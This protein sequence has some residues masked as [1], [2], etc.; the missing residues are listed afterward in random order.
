MSNEAFLI[1]EDQKSMGLLL[2]SELQKLTSLPIYI[3]QSLAETEALLAKDIEIVACL[4]DLTLPDAARG[5]AV[6]L[7]QKHHVT[8]VVLT[9]SYS[10]ETRQ[11]MFHQKVADYVIKDGPSSIHYAVQTLYKLYK[12]RRRHIYLLSHGSKEVSKLLGLLRIHRYQVSLYESLHE[13]Q[14]ELLNFTPELILLDSADLFKEHELYDFVNE[15][16]QEFSANQ[17]PMIACETSQ[18]ITSAIK[19][20]KYGVNDFF[21]TNFTAEEFYARVNQNIEQAESFREI[22]RISQTDALT[23][24]YNRGH[25]FQAG[26]ALFTQ[27]KTA[28]KYFFVVM[29]DIDHFKLVNDNH[30]HQKG[31]DAIVYTAK[32]IQ[33]VFSDHLVARFGGEEFCVLGEAADAA[34][35]ETLCEDLRKTIESDATEKTGVP[36]TISLGLTYSGENLEEA[37][38]K[39]DNALYRSKESGRNQLSTEF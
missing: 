38:S 11:E 33:Q 8:T 34:E 30:G 28:Q 20:M 10:E 36:F 31:D 13:L 16:R 7:L 26:E 18:H 14:Q 15:V 2:Q 3:C 39:A 27:L 21:N 22:E 9:G 29:A 4:S 12:N 6:Q 37:V 32:Q 19:L 5:E 25:F 24:I 17:L 35:I 1:I 23:G